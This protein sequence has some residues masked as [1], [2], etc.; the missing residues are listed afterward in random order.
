MS[1]FKLLGIPP[2]RA[3]MQ[4]VGP[5]PTV[6][7]V[8]DKLMQ[9]GLTAQDLRP[10]D[11]RKHGI[12]PPRNQQD[13]GDCWAM[14]STSALTDRFIIQKNISGLLLEAAITAQ[15][16]P[17]L[18]NAGCGGGLPFLAGQFFETTGVP[19]ISGEC[20][21]W[22]D[23]CPAVKQCV[24][25]TCQDM[26]SKCT[27]NVIYKAAQGSTKNLT[28]Q[29]ANGLVD[30]TLTVVNIKTELMNGPVVGSFYVPI[31]FMVSSVYDWGAT[32]GIYINGAYNDILDGLISDNVKQAL[33]NPRGAGWAAIM[34]EGGSQAAHA[35]EIVGWDIGDAGSK[36]GK[37]PYWIVKNSW[38]TDWREGGYFRMA[39]N[40]GNGL[41]A[42]CG[43][44]VPISSGQTYFGG[45]V[46][47]A[48][49][50]NTGDVRG[51]SFD[52]SA[53]SWKNIG[54]VVAGLLLLFLAYGY[55]SKHHSGKS[56]RKK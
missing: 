54:I 56:K 32:N 48:P 38:G 55:L 40:E 19:R 44:D 46:S 12:S 28:A 2:N 1:T 50:I 21:P 3:K 45:C 5:I 11:W 22:R 9:M 49:D 34:V 27:S 35:V 29:A 4:L 8:N 42:A 53:F 41:N 7:T 14:S 10:V 52:S 13:C 39:I 20:Q 26:V 23:L 30:P 15:C 51:T 6:S 17:Q 33:G 36:Y 16:V 47:F 37:I 18:L 24:L 43:I 25:P 31:D